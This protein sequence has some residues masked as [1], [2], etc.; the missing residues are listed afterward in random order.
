MKPIEVELRRIEDIVTEI[1]HD[2]EY[3]KV[4]EQNMRNTNESTNDRVKGFAIL[5]SKFVLFWNILT[6]RSCV[7]WIDSLANYLSSN[8]FQTQGNAGMNEASSLYDYE[9]VVVFQDSYEKD[10]QNATHSLNKSIRG[11]KR[12]NRRYL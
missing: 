9:Y 5:T 2:M 10:I 4:R 6:G 3:L 8:V 1:V 7:A 12:W 11:L